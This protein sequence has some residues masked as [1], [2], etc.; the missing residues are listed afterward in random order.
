MKKLYFALVAAAGMLFATSCAKDAA[1]DFAG[2][3]DEG[4]VT[5]TIGLEKGTTTR[6]VSDGTTAKDLYYA[7]FNQNTGKLVAGYELKMHDQKFDDLTTQVKFRLVKGQTYKAVFW[8]QSENATAFSL[9]QSE[10]KTGISLSYD[11]SAAANNDENLDAFYRAHEF[12]VT[13]A[14]IE[15]TI[16]L[17]RP[18]AQI[19][20]GTTVDDYA[21][22]ADQDFTVTHSEVEIAKAAK[23]LNLL[24]GTVSDFATVKF[25]MNDIVK[26]DDLLLVDIDGDGTIDEEKEKFNYLS[27]CYILTPDESATG[28]EKTLLDN[29]KFTIRAEGSGQQ[30]L[31]I[32]S[33][34]SNVPVQRNWR[35]NIVGE[36]LTSEVTFNIIIDP[37]YYGDYT[38]PDFEDHE[39]TDGVVFYDDTFFLS[40][41]NGLTWFRNQVNNPNHKDVKTYKE[42]Q[43][44][45][46]VG[47]KV[48]LTSDIDLKSAK[49]TPV[50]NKSNVFTGTFDGNNHT[51]SNLKVEETGDNY[52]ALFASVIGTVQ[53]VKLRDVNISGHY[54]AGAV[55]GNGYCA[56][57]VNC[58]VDGGTITSTPVNGEGGLHVGGISG[59]LAAEPTSYIDG[60]SVRNLKLTG[61]GNIGGIV[62]NVILEGTAVTNNVV[63]STNI[64]ANMLVEHDETT[65]ISEEVAGEITGRV[66]GGALDKDIDN[67]TANNVK[68][69][70]LAKNEDGVVNVSSAEGMF[71]A[72]KTLNK[73]NK[74]NNTN[75]EININMSAGEHELSYDITNGNAQYYDFNENVTLEGYGAT[76]TGAYVANF[77]GATIKGLTFG[78]CTRYG[79]ISSALNGKFYDCTFAA[80]MYSEGT[81]ATAEFHNCTFIKEADYTY[82]AFQMSAMNVELTLDKCTIDGRSDLG[83]TGGHLT[84]DGCTI[85]AKGEFGIYGNGTVTYKECKFTFDEGG[86]YKNY[87]DV[88]LEFIGCEGVS[89]ENVEGNA[90]FK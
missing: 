41:A 58:H 52:A 78:D 37:A 27:M 3:N 53:N 45:V 71:T 76:L 54:H 51:I 40:N 36:L 30:D 87:N 8:A 82:G 39:I 4:L 85:N 46:F 49:W 50:G 66:A 69:E 17:R 31:V 12:V 67:N 5:F 7:V 25:A 14:N 70:I 74:D 32:A 6:A 47:Q 63:E 15:Q 77:E 86:Y 9:S 83:M 61:Y 19:N 22:A 11:Y 48:M 34:L 18:F 24:D 62:G 60:C 1:A 89:S 43:L 56:Q 84:F 59:S 88:T 65:D 26:T 2:G 90:T 79:H 29:L 28:T 57:I 80:G 23:T 73:E 10:D 38:Y 33:G 64:I 35:T 16:T 68:I 81:P 44:R 72:L 13:E 20:L 55:V 42:G 75:E 21:I